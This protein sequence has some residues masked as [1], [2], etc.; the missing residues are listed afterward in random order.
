MTTPQPPHVVF[1]ENPAG[2][3]TKIHHDE[4]RLVPTLTETV[5]A[6]FPYAY[7]FVIGVPSGDGDSLDCFVVSERPLASGERV[8]CHPIGLLEQYQNG[9]DDHDVL[10]VP[11]DEVDRIDAI[12]LDEVVA[13]LRSFMAKVFEHDPG[14]ILDVGELWSAQRATALIEASRSGGS[15]T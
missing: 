7:G 8:E 10:A 9:L 2:S 4:E 12:D 1:V 11:V 6:P 15:A 14:R 3:T 5:S 13:T